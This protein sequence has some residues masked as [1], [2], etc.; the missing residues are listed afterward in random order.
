MYIISLA[1]VATRQRMKSRRITERSTATAQLWRGLEKAKRCP[2]RS[3]N[4][5]SC[6]A[7]SKSHH[8]TCLYHGNPVSS[9][10]QRLARILI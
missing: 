6:Q 1:F 10:L 4:K 2:M 9:Q 5:G 3:H 7:S 8:I